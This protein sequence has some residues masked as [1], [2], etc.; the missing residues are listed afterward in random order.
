MNT[1]TGHH[2]QT[3]LSIAHMR[4]PPGWTEPGQRPEFDEFTIVLQET[5]VVKTHHGQLTAQAGPGAHTR[6][7]Q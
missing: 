2:G 1:W 6:P 4:S 3:G 5:S 7:G